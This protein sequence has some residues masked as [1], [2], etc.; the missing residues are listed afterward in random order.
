MTICIKS[1]RGDIK[2]KIP[3]ELS[4]IGTDGLLQKRHNSAS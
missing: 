4:S 1:C 3:E 2:I